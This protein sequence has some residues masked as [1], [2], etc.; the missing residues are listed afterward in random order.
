[1]G[2]AP[3]GIELLGI[4]VNALADDLL[5]CLREECTLLALEVPARRTGAHLVSVWRGGG[6][7]CH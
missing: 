4:D 1:L 2:R 6:E 3:F 7:E 5:A